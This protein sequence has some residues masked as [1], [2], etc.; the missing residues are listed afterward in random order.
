MIDEDISRTELI[1]GGL[2]SGGLIVGEMSDRLLGF[3]FEV[4]ML[5]SCTVRLWVSCGFSSVVVLCKMDLSDLKS[6]G[7]EMGK[8]SV[9]FSIEMKAAARDGWGTGGHGVLEIHQ[10]NCIRAV[11]DD[12]IGEYLRRQDT[13]EMEKLTRI[14]RNAEK[15]VG[16]ALFDTKKK[17]D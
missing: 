13:G 16:V 17:K 15:R 9:G 10:M 5:T 7:C 14:E 3:V 11:S 1:V 2:R 8:S 6:C 4:M 12:L